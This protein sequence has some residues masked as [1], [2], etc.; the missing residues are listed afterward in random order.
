RQIYRD[1]NEVVPYFA[2]DE[3]REAYRGWTILRRY[4]GL[5]P[6]AQDGVRHLHSVE[7]IPPDGRSPKA[8]REA[9]QHGAPSGALRRDGDNRLGLTVQEKD[10]DGPRCAENRLEA[11][12]SAHP[13]AD[14]GPRRGESLGGDWIGEAVEVQR[15]CCR[16]VYVGHVVDPSPQLQVLD[17]NPPHAQ[18]QR[19]VVVQLGLVVSVVAAQIGSGRVDD[20]RAEE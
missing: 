20:V 3:L 11:H 14:R 15:P 4:E 12:L 1:K 10:P 9:R 8:T 2:P 13:A 19:R 7:T 16:V 17:R 5:I 6:C 18:V